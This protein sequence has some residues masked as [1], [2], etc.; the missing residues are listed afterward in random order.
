M[1]MKAK[2]LRRIQ[3]VLTLLEEFSKQHLSP[4]LSRFV[5]K[6]WEHIG[7][8]RNYIITGGKKEAWASAVVYVIARLNFLFDKNNPNYLP[9]DTI[10]GFFGSKKTTVAAR[11]S[12][13]EKVC[14]I[15]MG[16]EGLCSPEISDSL[17]FVELPNGM[18]LTKKMAREMGII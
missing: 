18:V 3:D 6:L 15:H 5:F 4:E 1:D 14:K 7:K 9:P 11:A 10:C 2:K 16:Q 8:K 12:E 17:T 13:I